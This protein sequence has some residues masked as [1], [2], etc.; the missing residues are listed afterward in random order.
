[1]AK[2]KED[3]RGLRK[4]NPRRTKVVFPNYILKNV[5]YAVT[6]IFNLYTKSALI[7]KK[8]FVF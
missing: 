1:M 4:E 3:R 5:K 2:W 6:K 8:Y 7:I